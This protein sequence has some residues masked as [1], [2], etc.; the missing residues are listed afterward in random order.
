MLQKRLRFRPHGAIRQEMLALLLIEEPYRYSFF[1]LPGVLF[2][3]RF[4]SCWTSGWTYWE[5]SPWP[6]RSPSCWATSLAPIRRDLAGEGRVIG[7]Q[8]VLRT[9][10]TAKLGARMGRLIKLVKCV[11]RWDAGG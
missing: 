1:F 10:R 2:C 11:S 5:P 6:L 3:A 9:A 7:V 4:I 8:V